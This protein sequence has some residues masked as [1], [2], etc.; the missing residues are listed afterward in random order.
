MQIYLQLKLNFFIMAKK[1][2]TRLFKGTRDF[3]P[4]QMIHRERIL[5][6]M[7]ATFQKFGFEPIETPAIEYLS[8][9]AGKYG[10]D[11]DRLIYRLNYKTGT[12]DEAALHYDL[13]V[14]FSRFMAMNPNLPKPFKR[15]QIQPVWRA[16]R[17][18]PNQGRFREFYQCDI[19]AVGSK[20]M[21]C[22][23]EIIAIKNEILTELGF[24]NFIIKINNRKLLNGL[25]QYAGL[26]SIY[27]QD[28][29]RNI[30]KLDK[31][32]FDEVSIE[33]G[34]IGIQDSAIK[35]IQYVLSIDFDNLSNDEVFKKLQGIFDL[36]DTALEGIEELKT[37]F[38]YLKVLGVPAENIKFDISL[39]RGL[40]YYTGTIY[41]TKLP[42]FPHIGSLTGGGRYDELIG[43]FSGTDLP[44]VGSSLGLDR[45]FTAMQQVGLITDDSAQTRTKVLFIHFEGSIVETLKTATLLRAKGINVEVYPTDAKLKKQF[46][47]ADKKNIPFVITLGVKELEGGLYNLKSMR[48]GGQELKTFD[49]I[50]EILKSNLIGFYELP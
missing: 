24:K 26:Q 10:E 38:D 34:M 5:A 43:M 28:V 37:L 33:L 20:S 14:P 18:Q 47:Y 42:D 12:K 15:Y 27:T 40:D 35:R 3:L 36:Y 17:P 8:I 41:E 19:D 39:A 48:H 32:S 44:A 23:A 25:V 31:M 49:E 6:V 29:C 13:T 7:R 2:P 22:D 11:A 9:L 4:A 1:L 46:S 16:D 30:D 45:I 21:M 50:V